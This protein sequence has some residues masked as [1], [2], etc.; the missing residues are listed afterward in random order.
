MILT[1]SSMMQVW[2]AGNGPATLEAA[3]LR[4]ELNA[5]GSDCAGL[6]RAVDGFASNVESF[7][8]DAR[9]LPDGELNFEFLFNGELYHV[10]GPVQKQVEGASFAA[11]AEKSVV[12]VV[13]SQQ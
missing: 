4:S 3:R 6:P 5:V 11:D 9:S 7:T 10:P 13:L 12:N 8:V 2:L 1:R